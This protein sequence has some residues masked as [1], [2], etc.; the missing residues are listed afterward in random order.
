MGPSRRISQALPL[1]LSCPTLDLWTSLLWS[2][3]GPS[4]VRRARLVAIPPLCPLPLTRTG[5]S[6]IPRGNGLRP[7]THQGSWLVGANLSRAGT[8]VH[9]AILAKSITP[10]SA[11]CLQLA[12]LGLKLTI[13]GGGGGGSQGTHPGGPVAGGTPAGSK[14]P[15]A[16]PSAA[17][18]EALPP[19]ASDPASAPA[20][21]SAMVIEGADGDES[22]TDSFCWEGDEDGLEF[23]LNNALSHYFT[24]RD[25]TS[26]PSCCHA[27]V[28]VQPQ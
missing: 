28:H 16:T 4:L 22:S 5:R 9:S 8:T 25:S 23:K 12:D 2:G 21:L 11:L 13:V 17:P 18:A 7:M 19:T 1:A 20:G 26:F 6:F 27:T 3:L 14:K 10:L 15:P 24:P